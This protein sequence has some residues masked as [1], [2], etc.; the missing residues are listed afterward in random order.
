MDKYFYKMIK[1]MRV[2][3]NYTQKQL[4]GGL[5][6]ASMLS[7]IEKGERIPSLEVKERMYERMGGSFHGFPKILKGQE[8]QIGTIKAEIIGYMKE[9]QWEKAKERIDDFE[10]KI[11]KNDNIL[12]QFVFDMRGMIAINSENYVEATELYA[13][14]IKSTMNNITMEGERKNL[15][16]AIE[17]YYVLM[18]YYCSSKADSNANI[19]IINERIK[20]I[21]DRIEECNIDEAIK[22][23]LYGYAIVRYY[24]FVNATGLRE[25]IYIKNKIEIALQMLSNSGYSFNLYELLKRQID[26]C[27]KLKD[28][29]EEKEIALKTISA[30]DKIYDVA[31]IDNN[32]KLSIF[33]LYDENIIDISLMI[34][35]RRLML[36]LTQAKL[37][38]GICSVKTLQ[39]IEQ[40]SVNAQNAVL[41]PILNRLGLSSD[42]QYYITDKW[43]IINLSHEY[44]KAAK[45]RNFKKANYLI[46]CIEKKINTLP[47]NRQTMLMDKSYID[48]NLG[49]IS[50]EEYIDKLKEALK[51]T[52]DIN[53]QLNYSSNFFTEKEMECLFRLAIIENGENKE[54]IKKVICAQINNDNQETIINREL[55]AL[56]CRWLSAEYEKDGDYFTSDRYAL[57]ALQE[58]L[59]NN[60]LRTAYKSYYDIL[61]NSVKSGVEKD[62]YNPEL[63]QNL[64]YCYYLADFLQDK[65]I[66]EFIR[67]KMRIISDKSGNWV[68]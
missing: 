36:R 35:K 61:W 24:D 68:D 64:S 12:R 63:Y 14:A 45:K 58:E 34:K 21:I 22:G 13:N 2:N 11:D 32:C 20:D 53:K 8:Y 30:L 7:Y 39:R 15:L 6:S 46:G 37:V 57:K 19:Y 50:K 59:K 26:L 10:R 51:I 1:S 16:A 44:R 25:A 67:G 66:A 23:C 29:N 27:N 28:M 55:S 4:A 31:G 3:H 33:F 5:C 52:I 18:Y 62:L 60:R 41:L 9:S 65:T 48:Y 17:Y 38:E 40:G 49:N 42:Y 47:Q 43:E 54:R 56:L